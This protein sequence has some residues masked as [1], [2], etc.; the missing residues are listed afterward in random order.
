MKKVGI[1][2]LVIGILVTVVTSINVV[3]EKKVVDIGSLEI[4]KDQNNFFSWSPWIG[5][6][7][8]VIGGGL[9]VYGNKK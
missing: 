8:M 1:V 9:F 3:T 6:A 2:V 4:T 5:V 7:I